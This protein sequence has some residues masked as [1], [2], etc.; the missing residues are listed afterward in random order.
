MSIVGELQ[1]F[2]PQNTRSTAVA[3]CECKWVHC[4]Y[5]QRKRLPVI[6]SE[7]ASLR[8]ALNSRELEIERIL[9]LT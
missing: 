9:A 3:S 8:Q 1:L 5:C 4:K 7:I 6:K 2:I